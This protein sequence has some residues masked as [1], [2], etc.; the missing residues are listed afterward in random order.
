MG[1]FQD[2]YLKRRLVIALDKLQKGLAFH[3]IVSIGMILVLVPKGRLSLNTGFSPVVK[4]AKIIQALKGRKQKNKKEP[5]KFVGIA[6]LTMIHIELFVVLFTSNPVVISQV[7]PH[8]LILRD[9]SCF[10]DKSQ[11]AYSSQ[12]IGHC[13]AFFTS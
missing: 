9:V 10:T 8:Q 4:G 11:F 2:V 7:D 3:L 6:L 1:P 13:F 12:L 5:I